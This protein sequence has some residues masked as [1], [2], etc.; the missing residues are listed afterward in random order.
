MRPAAGDVPLS[1]DPPTTSSASAIEQVRGIVMAVHRVDADQAGS[2]LSAVARDHDLPVQVLAEAT[3]ETVRGL[4]PSRPEA[5]AVAIRDLLGSAALRPLM[6]GQVH[7]SVRAALADHLG[8]GD[9]SVDD[10]AL[11]SRADERDRAAERR[12]R[13]ADAR[14]AAARVRHARDPEAHAEDDEDLA[15]S[16]LD[17]FWAGADRDAAAGDRAALSRRREEPPRP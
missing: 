17:R 13:A 12:D 4:S 3:L 11:L 9:D 1:S 7:P 16:A 5:A 14:E 8:S 10:A 6:D 2:L 15:Q